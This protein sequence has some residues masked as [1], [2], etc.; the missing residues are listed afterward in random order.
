MG[1]WVELLEAPEGASNATLHLPASNHACRGHKLQS[2]RVWLGLAGLAIMCIMLHRGCRVCTSAS[3][4]DA[5]ISAAC[6]GD[7]ILR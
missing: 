6:A 2:A 1:H 3:L 4:H 7:S 5:P